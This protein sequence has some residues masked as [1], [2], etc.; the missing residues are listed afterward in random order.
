MKRKAIPRGSHE[1][2]IQELNLRFPLLSELEFSVADSNRAEPAASLLPLLMA[3]NDPDI[4][5][6]CC[7]LLP[8]RTNVAAFTAILIALNSIAQNVDA[9][10]E[11]YSGNGL[12]RGERVSVM[13]SGHVYEFGGLFGQHKEFFKLNILNS[14]SGECRS[15]PIREIIRLEKTEKTSPRGTG[16]TDLSVLEPA[17]ID[18]L[19]DIRT[20]GN[21]ALFENEIILVGAQNQFIDFMETLTICRKD[22]PD[23]RIRARDL[24]P[25]GVVTPEGDIDFRESAAAA[26]TPVIAVASRAE[27]AAEACARG[28]LSAPRVIVD[29][30]SRVKNCLQAFD[31]LIDDSKLLLIASH[32]GVD[33]VREFEDRNCE[34]WSIPLDIPDL[35]VG[36]GPALARCREVYRNASGFDLEV[37]ECRSALIDQV[38]E[39]LVIAE[40]LIED[41]EDMGRLLSGIYTLLIDTA[42]YIVFSEDATAEIEQKLLT[43]TA[44]IE[45]NKIWFHEDFSYAVLEA[46]RLLKEFVNVGE[47]PKCNILL[48]LLMKPKYR[49]PGTLISAEN[50]GARKSIDEVIALTET[51]FQTTDINALQTI[52]DKS[53]LIL[54]G[55]PRS[56]KFRKVLLGYPVCKVIAL[57]YP[58]EARWYEGASRRRNR[59]LARWQSTDEKLKLLANVTGS[60]GN[61]EIQPPSDEPVEPFDVYKFEQMV[62]S[63]RTSTGRSSPSADFREAKMVTFSDGSYAWLTESFKVP[64]ITAIVEG[65]ARESSAVRMKSVD[66]LEINDYLLFREKSD[67][68]IIRFVAERLVGE[69]KYAALKQKADAW[70]A[71]LD[72]LPG[73]A[74]KMYKKL[75]SLGFTKTEQTARNW[76]RQDQMIGP[77]DIDDLRIIANAAEDGFLQ[78]NIDLVWDAMNH[79]R[80]AHLTAGMRLSQILVRQ[81]PADIEQRHEENSVELEMDGHSLGAALIVKVDGVAEV[82][83]SIPAELTNHVITDL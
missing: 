76:C 4:E 58:F 65:T 53:T 68:D 27:Y 12:S 49:A 6:D 36:G 13:P 30:V 28:R 45:K 73:D 14:T 32:E 1:T 24:I 25:W 43:L 77:G 10:I 26:G 20:Y 80:R 31:T 72:R 63:S 52:T 48:D 5:G 71:A 39:H 3:M 11:Q 83:R 42:G 34:V 60:L 23:I 44:E 9:A 41:N 57:C 16:R 78:Q 17:P 74:S 18:F 82:S 51:C 79:I 70:R 75:C 67:R 35:V 81:L 15:F 62:L 64:D 37:V 66:E 8:D 22:R 56:R 19:L 7:V 59:L 33:H 55:W 54:T 2:L 21:D 61:R 47:T 38:V 46:C 69:T 40:N 29:G 50:S